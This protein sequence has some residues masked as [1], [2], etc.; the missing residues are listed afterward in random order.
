MKSCTLLIVEDD[1][2]TRKWEDAYF[3]QS[4]FK[5]DF[6]ENAKETIEKLDK[7]DFDYVVTDVMLPVTTGLDL[8][9]MIAEN[10]PQTK[11]IL[12]SAIGEFDIYKNYPDT[13]GFIEKP[14]YPYKV[15]ELIEEYEKAA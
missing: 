1:T 7:K 4:D 5:Y 8:A 6:A 10:Y 14:L 13:I 12:C 3:A 2:I 15:A 11:T 9:H